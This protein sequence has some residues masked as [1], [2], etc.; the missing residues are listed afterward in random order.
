MSSR[1]SPE[2]W[3]CRLSLSTMI[4]DSF[5]LARAQS[6]IVFSEAGSQIDFND[7]QS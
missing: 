5:A 7:E 6:S 4:D 2:I 1:K 3:K